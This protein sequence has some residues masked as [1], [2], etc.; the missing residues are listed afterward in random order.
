MEDPRT[1]DPIM[2]ESY[3]NAMARSPSCNYLRFS[4]PVATPKG[5]MT[6]NIT[7]FAEKEDI[8]VVESWEL[9]DPSVTSHVPGWIGVQTLDL[10]EVEMIHFDAVPSHYY[11]SSDDALTTV[12][13]I[14]AS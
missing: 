7:V 8:S 10:D 6:Y 14:P 13:S 5:E 3:F 4:L 2:K 1:Y 12:S 11:G 9:T